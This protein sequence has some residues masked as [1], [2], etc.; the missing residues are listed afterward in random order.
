MGFFDAFNLFSPVSQTPITVAPA[1]V[2]VTGDRQQQLERN[3]E[4]ILADSTFYLVNEYR[5]SIGLHA[6]VRESRIDHLCKQHGLYMQASGCISHDNFQTFR[7]HAV[8]ELGFTNSLPTENVG[9]GECYWEHLSENK[10][11]F[12]ANKWL[13][14]WLASTQGHAEN[15]RMQSHVVSGM[16]CII[17]PIRGGVFDF[18]CFVTQ[19]FGS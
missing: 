11:F 12:V 3:I 16:G 8:R 6:V 7:G 5:E 4:E 9:G 15:I 18:E 14:G 1:L 13:E 17:R 19:I 2:Q 10:A